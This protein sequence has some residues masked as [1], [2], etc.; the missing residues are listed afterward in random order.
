MLRLQLD[1]GILFLLVH[2]LALCLFF[3]LFVQLLAHQTTTL[4]LTKHCWL[5][6]LV[7]EKLVEFLDGGPLIFFCDFTVDLS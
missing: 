4:L 7:V 5:L 3:Q 1:V 2:F 6:L